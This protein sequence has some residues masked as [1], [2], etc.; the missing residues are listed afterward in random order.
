MLLFFTPF[1]TTIQ[2]RYN[3]LNK[4]IV[5]FVTFVFPLFLISF[6]QNFSD[7]I[8]SVLF[9]AVFLLALVSFVNLYEVGYIYNEAETIKKEEH[10]TK[11]LSDAELAFYEK[12]KFFIYVERFLLSCVLNGILSV[13]ISFRSL[14]IF[15][16][17][18]ILTLLVFF[19]YNN[20][21]GNI[22]QAVYF[23][24]CVLKYSSLVFCW[25][26]RVNLS[27]I[28]ACVFVFPIVRT[29]EYKAHYKNETGANLFFRKHIIHYDI[30]RIPV[31]RVIATLFLLFVS[32]A[33]WFFGVCNLIPA[34]ACTYMFTYR[35]ALWISVK[36]G[37]KFKGYL[38]EDK[39]K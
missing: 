13:F 37:A 29:L 35:F 19:L 36:M 18:E 38:Q 14:C 17:M 1:L 9:Y 4:V 23:F 31:F 28:L 39:Q 15:S 22:T 7:G 33:L 2:T 12:H 6:L 21:R 30:N 27:V 34:I 20:V 5:Y 24:L 26:E 8:Q 16:A 10:P 3:S 32:L 25:S 11:R